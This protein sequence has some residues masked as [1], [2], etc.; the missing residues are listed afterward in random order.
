MPYKVTAFICASYFYGACSMYGMSLKA[1]LATYGM[2]HFEDD[3]AN[4]SG[5]ESCSTKKCWCRGGGGGGGV[6]GNPRMKWNY[7]KE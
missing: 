5:V 2:F 3:T 1:D 6:E 7:L 4:F